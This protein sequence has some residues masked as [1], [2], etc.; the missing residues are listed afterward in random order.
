M[1]AV[2]ATTMESAATAAMEPIA[3]AEPSAITTAAME[4]AVTTVESPV[5]A[6]EAAITATKTFMAVVAGASIVATMT[7]IAATIIATTVEAAAVVPVIPGAGADKDTADEVV[8]AVVAVGCAGVWIVAVV[9]VGADRS[10]ADGAV[11]GAYPDG[12]AN[13]RVGITRG[14]KQNSQQCNIF[15][16]TH[17]VPLFPALPVE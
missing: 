7:V 13:L 16:V 3:A 9:A 12:N 8:R 10:R 17:L 2:A 6:T 1:A 5:T 14:K 11:N 4:S 15:Q